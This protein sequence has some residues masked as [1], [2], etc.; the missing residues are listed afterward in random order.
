MEICETLIGFHRN[1]KLLSTPVL[2]QLSKSGIVLLFPKSMNFP[3]C[4]LLKQLEFLTPRGIDFLSL[5][6]EPKEV[7]GNIPRRQGL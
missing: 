6:A 7:H 1:V 4:I 2:R 3:F 5:L